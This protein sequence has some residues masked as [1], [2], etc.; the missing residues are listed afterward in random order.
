MILGIPVIDLHP[1]GSHP[2]KECIDSGT[3][4]N[5]G[6]EGQQKVAAESS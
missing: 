4:N 6:V 5:I 2:P 3:R 1:L